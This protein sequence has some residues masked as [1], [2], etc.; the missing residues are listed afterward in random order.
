V[1][2]D[3]SPLREQTNKVHQ[4]SDPREEKVCRLRFWSFRRLRATLEDVGA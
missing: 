4:L 2:H 3:R 1:E